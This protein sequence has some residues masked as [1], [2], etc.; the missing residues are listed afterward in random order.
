MGSIFFPFCPGDKTSELPALCAGHT[1]CNEKDFT[2]LPT[3]FGWLAHYQA[4]DKVNTWIHT[5]RQFSSKAV[6]FTSGTVSHYMAIKV[7]R[8]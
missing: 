3:H 4:T 5:L 7:Y 1:E 6:M 8:D 2:C